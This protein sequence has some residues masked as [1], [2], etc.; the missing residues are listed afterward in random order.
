MSGLIAALA[1]GPV[2]IVL[3]VVTQAVYVVMVLVTL[4]HLRELA[5]GMDPFDLMLTGY[6]LAYAMDF[7]QA[8]GPAGRDYYLSRQI[9]LDL[10]YPG[11]F[12]VTFA[13]IWQ[14]LLSKAKSRHRLLRAMVWLPVIAGLADYG[15]NG[16]IVAMLSTYPD[17]SEALVTVASALTVGKA[18]ATTVYFVALMGLL[19]IL[20]RRRFRRSR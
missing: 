20:A 12:A 14:W 8:I 4:P 7:V 15:E 10:F 19:T 18:A 5:G 9:P 6:D 3:F 17:L 1:R 13:A 11:L 16:C 2:I